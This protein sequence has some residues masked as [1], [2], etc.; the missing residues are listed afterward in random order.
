[1]RAELSHRALFCPCPGGDS[2]GAKRMYD[3]VRAGCIPVILSED[4]VYPWSAEAGRGDLPEASF[5]LRIPTVALDGYDAP[6]SQ[7]NRGSSTREAARYAVADD[8][9]ELSWFAEAHA[10]ATAAGDG[11]TLGA[12]LR[13]VSPLQVKALL[14]GVGRVKREYF[15]YWEMS[16]NPV[17]RRAYDA[18]GRKK[19]LLAVDEAKPEGGAVRA[20]LDSLAEKAGFPYRQACESEL[21]A[22][23][24]D[25][26]TPFC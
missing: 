17:Y 14:A 5:S 10:A 25:S 22:S 6:K 19:S 20:L 24:K 7:Q 3:V 8:W 16:G 11:H 15:D 1:M 18:N 2:P 21:Q 4:F 26:R 13:R 23:H 9:S 12:Y